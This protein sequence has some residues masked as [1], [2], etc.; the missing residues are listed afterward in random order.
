MATYCDK[1]YFA[2]RR[3]F[4]DWDNY[5]DDFPVEAT[6]D[7]V[8]QACTDIMNDRRHMN[9]SSNITTSQDTGT[10]KDICYKMA[11]RML[12]ME[13]VSGMGQMFSLADYL[14]T[15]ERETL[16][17]I[18]KVATKRTTGAVVF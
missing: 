16:I 15:G 7:L 8:L 18:A 13:V 12:G 11:S 1:D 14:T 17:S 2:Q 6:L 5:S 3:G 9:T 4:A 10:L